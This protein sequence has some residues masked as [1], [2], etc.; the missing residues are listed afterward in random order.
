MNA[1][2]NCANFP[3][4]DENIILDKILKHW[5]SWSSQI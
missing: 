5:N 1:V 3:A 2:K 4:D